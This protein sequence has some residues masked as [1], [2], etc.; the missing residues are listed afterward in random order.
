MEPCILGATPLTKAS[1]TIRFQCHK[2]PHFST[3]V[4]LL[5][6][7]QGGLDV[8]V[9]E[10][11]VDDLPKLRTKLAGSE[12]FQ[13]VSVHGFKMVNDSIGRFENIFWS[14][15]SYLHSLPHVAQIQSQGKELLSHGALQGLKRRERKPHS[16]SSTLIGLLYTC[17]Q[18]TPVFDLVI[19]LIKRQ[20]IL[21]TSAPRILA[22]PT[23]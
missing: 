1:L 12:H 22:G 15:L 19:T 23:D 13:S 18:E 5:L 3:P 7:F 14:S 8:P 16:V 9:D 6:A 20:K 11:F 10:S 21:V 4:E 2:L 17:L